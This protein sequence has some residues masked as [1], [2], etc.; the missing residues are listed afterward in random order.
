MDLP[1]EIG[2]GLGGQL[3][4]Q[5]EVDWSTPRGGVSPG[6]DERSEEVLGLD[7]PVAD[8]D[9]VVGVVDVAELVLEEGIAADRACARRR[10]DQ[11]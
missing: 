5:L 4:G 1:V 9:R 3:R 8:I 11:I 2:R 6:Q 10:A 7:G